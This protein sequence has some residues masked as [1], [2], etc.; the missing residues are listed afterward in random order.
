MQF[1]RDQGNLQAYKLEGIEWKELRF[2][3]GES[4]R[5]GWREDKVGRWVVVAPQGR[6]ARR[7]CAVVRAVRTACLPLD[8]TASPTL[9]HSRRA[10]ASTLGRTAACT[11]ARGRRA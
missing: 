7:R 8:S 5:G 3:N 4:Y 1:L 6:Q 10:R 2:E 9:P 11:R